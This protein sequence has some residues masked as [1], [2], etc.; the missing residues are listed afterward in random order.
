MGKGVAATAQH[1]RR[2]RGRHAFLF[3]M[4]GGLGE[5]PTID[6]VEHLVQRHGDIPVVGRGVIVRQ[7]AAYGVLRR[8][9]STAVSGHAVGYCGEHALG[10]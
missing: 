10:R 2:Q 9:A 1:Q 8:F 3:R 4:G 5:Q 7:Q 6:G